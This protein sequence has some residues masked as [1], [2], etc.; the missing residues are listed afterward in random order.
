M[1][2][3]EN[4]YSKAK[5]FVQIRRMG[6]QIR[7][8]K[9]IAAL[10]TVAAI[11]S[12]VIVPTFAAPAS[13]HYQVTT[14][15][16]MVL[17]GLPLRVI[18]T[19]KQA[20]PDC[21]YTVDLRVTGPGGVSATDTVTVTTEA[22]GNGHAAAAFPGDFAGTAST[23]TAGTYTVTATFACGYSYS[24]GQATATFTVFK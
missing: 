17:S 6:M 12:I 22:G 24:T 1:K 13:Q 2:Y 14:D 11:T 9:G 8:A 18:A 23:S 15:K 5:Y 4:A 3:I 7:S 10:L 16:K 21:A 19:I 20:T